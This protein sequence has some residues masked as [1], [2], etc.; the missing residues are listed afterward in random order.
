MS[1]QAKAIRQVTMPPTAQALA[2]NVVPTRNIAMARSGGK[3]ARR[4]PA[5]HFA[6]EARLVERNRR[7]VRWRAMGGSSAWRRPAIL[8]VREARLA[9]RGWRGALAAPERIRSK[10]ER[11][12][13]LLQC[14]ATPRSAA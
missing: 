8:V 5:L 3:F 2:A 7:D 4:R 11:L 9:E 12:S 1:V 13:V 14:H 10:T 6:R